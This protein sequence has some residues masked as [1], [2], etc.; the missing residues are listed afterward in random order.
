MGSHIFLVNPYYEVLL[1]VLND[2]YIH[3]YMHTG[4]ET[5]RE[6]AI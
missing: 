5:K 3:N 1:Y 6:G 4:T 2:T